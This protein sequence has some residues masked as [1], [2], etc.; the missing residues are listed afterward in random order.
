MQVS[1]NL[2]AWS[3]LMTYTAAG[4]WITNSPGATLVES[5]TNGVPPNQF[6]NE[7]VTS[8]TNAT[9]NT[10]NQFLRLEVHR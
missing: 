2:V 1:T 9:V 10:V 5:A 8:S 6:V 7:T 3:N 4:G